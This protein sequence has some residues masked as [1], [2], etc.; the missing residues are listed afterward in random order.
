MTTHPLPIADVA[1]AG[2]GAMGSAAA[3]Q[4]ASR[5]QRVIGFDR[6][7][8]PHAMGSSTGRSRIIR[9]AYW[10]SPFYVPLVRRAYELWATLER[11]SGRA[12]LRP[13]GGLVIGPGDGPLVSG[14][15]ASAREHGVAFDHLGPHDI[16]ARFPAFRPGAHLEGVFEPRAGVLMPEDAIGAMLGEAVKAG[17]ELRFDEPVQRWERHGD[18]ILV[19]TGHGRYAARRVIL[20]AGAWMASALPGRALPLRVARQTMFWLRPGG[21]PAG[22]GPGQLP[23]W[24]WESGEGPVYYG[25]PDL[26][27]G[28]KVARHHDGEPCD[29]DTVRREVAPEESEEIARFL[30][31]SIPA[32]AGPVT[33]ARVCLYT[34]TPDEHFILDRHPDD[35]AVL[36]ASPCSGHGFKFAPT[37]GELLADLAMDRT[38]RFDVTPFCLDRFGTDCRTG[39]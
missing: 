27:D 32:L 21:D 22:L 24:L 16:A 12:L 6:F 31:G 17:A 20:A 35:P 5:G 26:G 25:F 2:L 14:A 28:P 18:A 13:T 1:I 30:A 38:P 39:P 33:D 34:N 19:H 15:I 37:I 11:R 9:E 36:I 3:W 23:I 10:E 29:P 4:L 8:P 7:R